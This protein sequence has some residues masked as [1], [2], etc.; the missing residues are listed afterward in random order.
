MS[1]RDDAI[2]LLRSPQS[3]RISFSFPSSAGGTI[4][5]NNSTFERVATKIENDIISIVVTTR[6][7]AGIGAIYVPDKTP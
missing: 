1:T 7:P 2:R 5:V 6:L 3:A 4:T